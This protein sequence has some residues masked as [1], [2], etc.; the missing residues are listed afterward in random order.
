MA[1]Y[2]LTQVDAHK[3]GPFV[4]SNECK[5]LMIHCQRISETWRGLERG[6]S[7]PGFGDGVSSQQRWLRG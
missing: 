7:A 5:D 1:C 3:S 6:A 4:I 2:E